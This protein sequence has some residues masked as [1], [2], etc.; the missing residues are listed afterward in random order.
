MGAGA[1]RPT[2]TAALLEGRP[3][4]AEGVPEEAVTRMPG[5][6]LETWRGMLRGRCVVSC[7]FVNDDACVISVI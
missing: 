7:R 1:A 2:S 6:T 4:G 5:F 3:W